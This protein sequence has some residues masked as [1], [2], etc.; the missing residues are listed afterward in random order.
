MEKSS[1]EIASD[2][3]A[4]DNSPYFFYNEDNCGNAL[5][6]KERESSCCKDELGC[7]SERYVNSPG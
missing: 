7:V 4:F 6:L 5:N 3:G 2:V 1:E